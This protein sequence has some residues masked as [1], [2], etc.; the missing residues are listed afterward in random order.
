MPVCEEC[1]HLTKWLPAPGD[2][3][4]EYLPLGD[5]PWPLEKGD[6]LIWGF[7]VYRVSKRA[8]GYA[9]RLPYAVWR[10]RR[11]KW[12]GVSIETRKDPKQKLLE[13]EAE[14]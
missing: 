7:H 3:E 2:V 1:G 6:L 10:A 13:W 14:G 9:K 4:E 11:K 8:R 5:L 12:R